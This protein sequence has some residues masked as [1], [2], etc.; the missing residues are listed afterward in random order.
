MCTNERF[1]LQIYPD[2]S[3]P[4]IFCPVLSRA[5]GVSCGFYIIFVPVIGCDGHIQRYKP[6]GVIQNMEYRHIEK[7]G[8]CFDAIRYILAILITIAHYCVL[9]E[10]HLIDDF[11]IIENRVSIFF[12]ISGFF[13][14]MMYCKTPAPWHFTK[15]RLKRLVPAYW[16]TILLSVCLLSFISNMDMTDFWSSKQIYSYLMANMSF[17]NFIEP[18]LPGVFENNHMSAVNGSLW[19]MKVEIMLLATVPFAHAAFKKWGQKKCLVSIFVL[20]T[21]Y[22]MT[23]NHLYESTQNEIYNILSRQMAGQLVYFYSG[24]CAYLYKDAILSKMKILLPV[25]IVG[26]LFHTRTEVLY[27]LSPIN[28]AI[29][30]IC[31]AFRLKYLNFA[32]RFPN[33]SYSM[34]LVHFPIIQTYI[35][36]GIHKEY[37][38]GTLA[39]SLLSTI[40]AAYIMWYIAE[41]PFMK[42]RA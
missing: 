1:V 5:V 23:M 9:S 38:I 29:I 37:P 41:R 27:L 3:I 35:H 15:K 33:I 25:S 12:I 16:A 42:K 24:A 19:T 7:T 2:W 18:G 26:Y 13:S 22:R 34:Y 32:S 36:F 28:L 30:V 6:I 20:S 8:N 14:F 11:N 4:A 39:L 31:V 10:T 21:L 17:A 40:M